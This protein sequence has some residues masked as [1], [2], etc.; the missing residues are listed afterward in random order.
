MAYHRGALLLFIAALVLMG[1]VFLLRADASAA[2]GQIQGCDIASEA[3]DSE[4]AGAEAYA[5]GHYSAGAT[6]YQQAADFYH[7]CS[8]KAADK[9]SKDL[10]FYFYVLDLAFAAKHAPNAAALSAR[11]RK[12]ADAFLKRGADPDL[13]SKMTALKSDPTH[14]ENVAGVSQSN[15]GTTQSVTPPR[16]S[17]PFDRSAC[18]NALAQFWTPYND[19]FSARMRYSGSVQKTQRLLPKSGGPSYFYGPASINII[20]ELRA[21]R[22]VIDAEEPKLRQAQSRI[23]ST[24]AAQTA[25]AV[26]QMVQAIQQ[27]DALELAWTEGRYNT[28]TAL[29]NG[30]TAPDAPSYDTNTANQL[31]GQI[32]TSWDQLHGP[33]ACTN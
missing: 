32:K 4:S 21:I 16:V 11:V 20:L 31:G 15:T 29:A 3:A 10:A 28:I 8:V 33:S 24:G 25:S 9:Q 19:W 17:G 12:E 13:A 1:S 7:L 6:A 18:V 2:T 5:R 14:P 22:S 23:D 26:G 27:L 30:R